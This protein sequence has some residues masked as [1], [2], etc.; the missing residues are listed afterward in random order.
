MTDFTLE[1][2]QNSPSPPAAGTKVSGFPDTGCAKKRLTFQNRVPKMGT[3]VGPNFGT[4]L[5]TACKAVPKLG[6]F[7]VP[8]FGTRKWAHERPISAPFA[9][10][11]AATKDHAHPCEGR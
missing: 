3:E 7:L 8:I 4:A 9:R 11:G 6:P 2:R 5:L 1:L 10:F